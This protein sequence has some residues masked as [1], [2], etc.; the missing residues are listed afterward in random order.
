MNHN[1]NYG[2][3][4][5]EIP[6]YGHIPHGADITEDDI[7]DWEMRPGFTWGKVYDIFTVDR[8]DYRRDSRPLIL[9]LINDPGDLVAVRAE[10]VRLFNLH[11]FTMTTKPAQ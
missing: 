6:V 3:V 8:D 10:D 1:A 9:S 4:V 2:A 5:K 11:R 7:V